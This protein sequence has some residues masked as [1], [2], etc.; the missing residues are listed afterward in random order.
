[1]LEDTEIIEALIE[2]LR[3]QISWYHTM[4]TEPFWCIYAYL[5]SSC[6]LSV[7][8]QATASYNDRNRE[9]TRYLLHLIRHK[10]ATYKISQ[11]LCYRSKFHSIRVSSLDHLP[12]MP[13]RLPG[14]RLRYLNRSQLWSSCTQGETLELWSFGHMSDPGRL[15]V[16]SCGFPWLIS[17]I[18]TFV[19]L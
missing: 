13:V 3:S 4:N 15:S 2:A 6:Y 12:I 19:R 14:L 8:R 16:K 5:H 11:W 17:L 1:M 7:S 9:Q 10:A 18:G